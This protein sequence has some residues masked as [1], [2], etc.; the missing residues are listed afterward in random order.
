MADSPTWPEALLARA[1]IEP[2]NVDVSDYSDEFVAGFLAGQRSVL[3]EVLAGRLRL[4][5]SAE[6]PRA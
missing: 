6:E 4:P 1:A 3:E 2:I 5:P